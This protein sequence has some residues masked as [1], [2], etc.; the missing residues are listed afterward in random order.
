[1]FETYFQREHIGRPFLQGIFYMLILMNMVLQH[2]PA[3]FSCQ[4]YCFSC[5]HQKD[6]H[7][8]DSGSEKH[9]RHWFSED[10]FVGLEGFS[11]NQAADPN[12]YNLKNLWWYLLVSKW[13]QSSPPMLHSGNT[14]GLL[15]LDTRDIPCITGFHLCKT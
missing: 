1:M 8:F 10:W 7:P 6:F 13:H 5:L 15:Y 3:R 4:F 14:L 9:G 12:D 2:C 11:D